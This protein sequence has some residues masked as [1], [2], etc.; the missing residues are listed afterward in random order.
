[1]SYI[2]EKADISHSFLTPS[3]NVVEK[4]DPESFIN[5]LKVYALPESNLDD[6][7]MMTMYEMDTLT[8]ILIVLLVLIL[9][10]VL[11]CCCCYCCPLCCACCMIGGDAAG[12]NIARSR[13]NLD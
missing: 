12:R 7:H 3:S 4:T 2:K 13:Q 6:I 9:L 11:L 8:L 10:C 1:M 5:V